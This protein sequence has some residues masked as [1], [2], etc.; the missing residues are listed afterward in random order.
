MKISKIQLFLFC[1]GLCH[2]NLWRTLNPT[3]HHRQMQRQKMELCVPAQHMIF[4]FPC[5]ELFLLF[6]PFIII[7]ILL[8]LMSSP[9]FQRLLNMALL[10][11]HTDSLL[12]QCICSSPNT[13]HRHAR[14]PQIISLINVMFS[15]AFMSICDQPRPDIA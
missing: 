12:F 11:R 6:S 10:H 8:I 1:L 7:I 9:V 13:N 2:P 15:C 3:I 14:S 4:F 5:T